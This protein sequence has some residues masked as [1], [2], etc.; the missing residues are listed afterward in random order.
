MAAGLPP[1]NPG[2]PPYAVR[3]PH[4][5]VTRVLTPTAIMERRPTPG[6][7]GFPAPPAVRPGPI[8]RVAIGTPRRTDH[9]YGGPPAPAIPRQIHPTAVRRQRTVEIILL[10]CH[11]RGRRLFRIGH[12]GG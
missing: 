5:P 1:A 10:D 11:W 4:P 2:R 8:A 6:K 12:L 9:A 7:R 3:A